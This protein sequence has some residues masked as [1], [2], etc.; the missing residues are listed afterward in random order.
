MF[1]ATPPRRTTRSSTRKRQRHLVQLVGEQLI[2]ELPRKVHQMVG[3]DRS[4]HDDRHEAEATERHGRSRHPEVRNTQ[5]AAR[6]VVAPPL[7][8]RAQASGR[9]GRRR[10]QPQN[11]LPQAQPPEAFGLSMVKPCCSIVSVKSMVAPTRYGRAHPVDDDRHAVAVQFDVAVEAALV[12]EQLVLHARAAAGLDGDP[13]AQVVAALLLEQ[14]ANLPGGRVGERDRGGRSVRGRRRQF[15][16]RRGVD[17]GHSI[18]PK[19]GQP[20]CRTRW[21]ESCIAHP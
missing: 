4:G 7:F 17:S 12:E 11:E 9:A 20:G 10:P 6:P 1:A 21:S 16:R 5:R 14:G 18:L 8:G 2:R 15:H 13:Q 19:E 3:R